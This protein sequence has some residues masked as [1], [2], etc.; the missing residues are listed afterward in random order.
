MTGASGLLGRYVASALTAAGHQVLPLSRSSSTHTATGVD[1][2]ATDYSAGH[3]RELLDGQDALVHLAAVRG[4]P[5]PLSSFAVNADLTEA[6]LDACGAAAVPVAVVASSI[7]VYSATSPQPW[8]ESQDVVPFNNYGLSKLAS[9]KVAARA[10][11]RTGIQVT[12]L[13]LGHLYGALEDNSYLVNRFFRL[14]F[15]GRP[16]RVTPPSPNKREMLYAGDAASACAAAV[17]FGGHGVVNVPGYERLSNYEIAT[18]VARGFGTGSEVVV[19][20]T[21]EDLVTPTAMDGARARDVLGYIPRW[22][23]VDACRTIR[24]EMEAHRDH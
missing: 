15:E 19:D 12:S 10:A 23:M 14:A 13:R 17:Q 3:L 22:P 24:A 18:A 2:V 4:G 8:T 1:L 21:L 9:E 7:S 6:V 16:L 11:H 5:G 20:P